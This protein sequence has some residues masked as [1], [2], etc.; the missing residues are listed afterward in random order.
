MKYTRILFVL[1]GLLLGSLAA[2]QTSATPPPA[3]PPAPKL[4]VEYTSFTLANGLRVILHEDHSVPVATVNMWYHVGSARER[5]GRT[6]F[7][8]LFE[9]LMFMG[10]GHVR[11]GEFDEWLES[12]GGSNNGSTAEDRTNYWINVPSNALELALFLESDRMGYLLDTMTPQTVDAQRDV[13]KNERRQS[14][15]NRPYGQ[16]DITLTEMLYPEGHPYHWPV[17]GYM[18]DLTAASYDDVVG[19][20]KKYYAP[21]NASLVVAGDIDTPKTRALVEKWFGD[22][23]A[24]APVEPLTVPGVALT[25]VQRKTLTDR[26]QLP[27]LYL[28][29]LTPPH[30]APSDAALDVVADVLTGGKNSRLYKRLV[31][32]LQIAQSI[33]AAQNS[34]ALSSYFVIEAVP[35]PGHTVDELLKIIDEEIKTLQSS[36]PSAR[37]VQRSVNGIEASFYNRMERVGGFGG[38]GDQLNSY[39]TIT[40]DPDW[41][42]EDLARYRALS[43]SD[44]QA[45]A[46][47]FLPQDRR[48]ELTVVPERNQ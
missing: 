24:G 1:P 27:K 45:A 16:A 4:E 14:Y 26:V 37:E 32:D 46:A 20:F 17:I 10:S 31:Y 29:W 43:P 15:E 47:A 5:S 44:V 38:K 33:D 25:G 19:F 34:Q 21:S 2:A 30:L 28:A 18:P 35:R 8:H 23:K 6:G 9:H 36:P 11:P 3:E 40:G 7:A 39:Y 48:V 12:V 22:V 42:N 41:F 13:V